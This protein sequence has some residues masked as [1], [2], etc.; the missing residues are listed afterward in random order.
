[1]RNGCLVGY[2]HCNGI[3]GITHTLNS[4]EI[5]LMRG[6]I[7]SYFLK[8]ENTSLTNSFQSES[9][10]IFDYQIA[11]KKK[12]KNDQWLCQYFS[13]YCQDHALKAFVSRQHILLPFSH[14]NFCSVPSPA[15]CYSNAS[16]TELVLE[17]Q[18]ELKLETWP[19]TAEQPVQSTAVFPSLS[20]LSGSSQCRGHL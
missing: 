17:D 13:S 8:K 10:P 16:N 12:K 18:M 1:M 11:K 6:F 5:I 4:Y 14:L 15:K 9:I 7:F 20:I 3:S 19:R 2:S